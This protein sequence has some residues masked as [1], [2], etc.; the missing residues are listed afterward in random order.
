MNVDVKFTVPSKLCNSCLSVGAA[1]TRCDGF[2]FLWTWSD[3]LWSDDTSKVL[4]LLFLNEALLRV[5]FKSCFA[6]FVLFVPVSALGIWCGEVLIIS[7][8][9]LNIFPS[10]GW[11]TYSSFLG[12]GTDGGFRPFWQQLPDYVPTRYF[13]GRLGWFLPVPFCLVTSLL[14]DLARSGSWTGFP[15]NESLTLFR[16][17][18]FKPSGTG[19]GGFGGLPSL[20]NFKTVNAMARMM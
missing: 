19:G 4:N 18:F 11:G 13:L 6:C 16:P 3:T 2:H 7:E 1:T 8:T 14:Y 12:Q 20:C 5:E 10:C 9:M 17:D 15:F